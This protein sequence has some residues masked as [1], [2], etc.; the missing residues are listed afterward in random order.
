MAPSMEVPS[1]GEMLHREQPGGVLGVFF[2]G[3]LLLFDPFSPPPQVA[4]GVPAL[5]PASL[6]LLLV[7]AFALCTGGATSHGGM[8]AGCWALRLIKA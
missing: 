1:M 6:R 3:G 4:F 5:H 2:R 7:L 8:V